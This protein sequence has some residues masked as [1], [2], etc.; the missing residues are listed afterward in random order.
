[1]YGA[2]VKSFSDTQPDLVVLPG[3]KAT[4]SDLAW[5]RETGLADA[6][7]AH[8]TAGKPL[9]GIWIEDGYRT[10]SDRASFS[11]DSSQKS[12]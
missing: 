5:L 6:V 2:V 4:V 3:S 1:M 7:R 8:A 12:S 11:C 9:L 10:I